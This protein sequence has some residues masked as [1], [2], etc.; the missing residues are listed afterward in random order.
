MITIGNRIKSLRERCGLSQ[1]TL[2]NYIGVSSQAVSKWEKGNTLPSVENIKT[3][4]S[5][6]CVSTDELFDF[7]NYKYERKIEEIVKEFNNEW[8]KDSK[9]NNLPRCREIIQNGL[10][11]YPKEVEL[12]YCYIRTLSI[13]EN[14]E[15]IICIGHDIAQQTQNDETRFNTYR[16][17]AEA[18]RSLG[19]RKLC[20]EII[21]KIP[22]ITFS[23]K[24]LKAVLL[25]K[26]ESF[27]AAK[28]E[29]KVLF[30]HIMNMLQI[31]VDYYFEIGDENKAKSQLLVLNNIEKVYKESCHDLF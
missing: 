5:L 13:P 26:N 8:G 6:F 29:I 10:N 15:E 16:I 21:E 11:L 18:Y 20:E 24:Y 7:S 2:A 17:L 3:I 31:I 23:K 25:D 27:A 28:E 9:C 4:A 14:S 22:N 19:E 12:L 30:K 1:E